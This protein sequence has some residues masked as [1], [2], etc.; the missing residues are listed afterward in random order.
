[1]NDVDVSLQWQSSSWHCKYFIYHLL[2]ENISS[3]KKYICIFYNP[4]IVPCR[5]RRFVDDKIENL[6]D[7]ASTVLSKQFLSEKWPWHKKVRIWWK[8]MWQI[9]KFCIKTCNCVHSM[10]KPR[11]E[12]LGKSNICTIIRNL[13][14]VWTSPCVVSCI[15]PFPSPHQLWQSAQ[16]RISNFPP[17]HTPYT[18]TKIFHCVKT[19]KKYFIQRLPPGLE[20]GNYQNYQQSI[21]CHPEWAT[22]Q[23]FLTPLFCLLADFVLNVRKYFFVRHQIFFTEVFTR[24]HQ[25]VSGRK[26]CV[27]QSWTLCLCGDRMEIVWLPHWATWNA[28]GWKN[29]NSNVLHHTTPPVLI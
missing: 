5:R 21:S 15:R 25:V 17:N 12:H 3:R 24:R 16:I 26:L 9:N 11:G 20:R 22:V 28:F 29:V 13:Q 19:S 27:V 23:T 8:V 10:H 1:M 18:I 7:V 4:A 14:S 6:F 2:L